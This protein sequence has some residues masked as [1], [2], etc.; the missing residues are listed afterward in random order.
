MKEMQ[1]IAIVDPSDATREPLRNQLLGLDS[2]WLEAECSRYEFFQ[3]VIHQSQPDIAV[4]VLD[5]DSNKALQLIAQLSAEHPALPVLAVTSK[6]DGQIV[7][8]ALR[9]GAKEFLTAPVVL[10]ELITAL[11]RLQQTRLALNG[12]GAQSASRSPSLVVAVAGSRGGVGCTTLAVN[13]GCTLAQNPQANVALLDLDLALGDADVAL[14]LMPDYTLA[15]VALNIDR[16]D[17]TFLRRSL[18]KHSTG[19]SLLPHPVQMEDAG[20]I[21]EEHIQRVLNLL[22]ASYTHL[23][24]DLSK[25][26]TPTDL[27]GLR[28]ADLVLLLC[29]LDLASLRNTV[30]LLH[31]LGND[32]D[33]REKIRVVLNR[34]GSEAD[35]SIG[36]AQETLG[37][38]IFW[39]LPNDARTL[40]ESRNA[41]VPL[42]Q[43]AP[44]SKF[45]QS[46]TDLSQ[47]LSGQPSA[48]PEGTRSGLRRFFS[49]K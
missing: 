9:N 33:L 35:I 20:L 16:L 14:D 39:Q 45:Q 30:R 24:L 10:E 1:R 47:T 37:Q 2:V 29:Q 6:G 27:A 38:P 28:M 36:K 4:V 3:E 42:L 13:L 15:D 23:I 32:E 12:R 46:I 25:G 18:S 22:R 43:H 21:K 34:V 31:T 26:F 48:A 41:G 44:R 8:Q 11:Q 19:L 40:I 49:F 7:L 17:M 5:T